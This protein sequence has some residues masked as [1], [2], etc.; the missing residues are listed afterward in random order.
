M[1]L[2]FPTGTLR[3]EL[4]TGGSGCD[5]GATSPSARMSDQSLEPDAAAGGVLMNG[6]IYVASGRR[7][8]LLVMELWFDTRFSNPDV[9]GISCVHAVGRIVHVSGMWR[10]WIGAGDCCWP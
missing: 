6:V 10:P 9:V 1:I 8:F 7:Q 5:T 3:W 2:T 4:R